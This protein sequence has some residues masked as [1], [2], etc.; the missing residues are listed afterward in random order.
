[1]W[2]DASLSHFLERLASF[3]RLILIDKRGTGLSDPVSLDR[4]PTLEQRIDD[5][6]VVMDAVGSE[7]AALLGISEGGPMNI[8]FAASHP[9]RTTA[10]VLLGT[11]ARIVNGDGYTLG[12]DPVAAEKALDPIARAWGQGNLARQV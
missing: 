3:S 8:L 9:Q 2:Q 11:F 10:L 6:R 4:L 7:R 12:V 5:V 1:M